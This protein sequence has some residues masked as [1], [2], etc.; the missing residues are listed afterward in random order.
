MTG[1]ISAMRL[2]LLKQMMRP[3]LLAATCAAAANAGHLSSL[4]L[5][6]P[7]AY[8]HIAFA[9]VFAGTMTALVLGGGHGWF[10]AQVPPSARA[11]TQILQLLLWAALPAMAFTAVATSRPGPSPGA[12]LGLLGVSISAIHVAGIAFFLLRSPLPTRLLPLALVA[13]AW[14]IPALIPT[15]AGLLDASPTLATAMDDPETWKHLAPSGALFLAAILLPPPS[16]T[17]Q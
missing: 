3:V 8:I 14:W 12:S 9:L 7:T 2:R 1:K 4:S 6:P 16:G 11:Q 13:L 10:L 5:Y 15:L 17:M